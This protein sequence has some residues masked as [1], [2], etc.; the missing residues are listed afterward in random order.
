[1][2][3]NNNLQ[4]IN[5]MKSNMVFNNSNSFPTNYQYIPNNLFLQKQVQYQN[6][7]ILPKQIFNQSSI[8]NQLNNKPLEIKRPSSLLGLFYQ[9]EI[10]QTLGLKFIARPPLENNPFI[11]NSRIKQFTGIFENDEISK[12]LFSKYEN[13]CK[14]DKNSRIYK[15]ALNLKNNNIQQISEIKKWNPF[16]DPNIISIPEKTILVANLPYKYNEEIL[17]KVFRIY[18]KI[19]NIRIIKKNNFSLGYGFIEYKNKDDCERAYEKAYNIILDNRKIIVDYEKGRTKKNFIPIKFGGKPPK[20]RR[21]SQKLEDE[22]EEVYQEYPEL[23]PENVLNYKFNISSNNLDF[24]K[25][26][27]DNYK[28]YEEGEIEK[29]LGEI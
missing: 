1:M 2:T 21:L 5:Q 9:N 19:E 13:N 8:Y 6:N 16:N 12:K 18:G 7:N 20:N 22:L 4:F 11:G 28:K 3:F 23:K 14:I 25:R 10:P 27:R 17:A 15:I 24:L 26:K 29:E